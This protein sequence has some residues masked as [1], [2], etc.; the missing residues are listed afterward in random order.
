MSLSSPS[1]SQVIASSFLKYLNASPSP[2]HA[3]HE[4]SLKLLAAGF[5]KLSEKTQ[6]WD[7]VPGKTYF[8]TRNERL[9]F[10]IIVLQYSNIHA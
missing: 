2:F 4:A 1:S 6:D 3:V 9:V 10:C 5:T 7:L 8:V